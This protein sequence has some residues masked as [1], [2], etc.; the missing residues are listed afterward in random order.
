M[1][2]VRDSESYLKRERKIDMIF[3]V[4]AILSSTAVSLAMRFSN[5]VE[6]SLYGK[7]VC[8]YVVCSLCAA[9]FV[10]T[11]EWSSATMS[12]G[13]LNG[14]LLV[15]GLILMQFS[16]RLNG[17]ALTSLYGR[18][19]VCIP[20][21]FSI[22]FF[23]ENPTMLQCV[24][25]LLSFFAIYLSFYQA[26]M[27]FRLGLSLFAFMLISG[28]GDTMSKIYQ[29]YGDTSFSGMYFFVSFCLAGLMSFLVM[30]YKKQRIHKKEILYG[31]L[32][33]V[34]NY[35]SSYFLL[36]SLRTVPSIVVYPTYSMMTIVV[37]SI[38]GYILF[39]E[40]INKEKILTFV[41]ILV[42]I[43]LLNV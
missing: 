1:M 37:I 29:M 42:S 36:E 7:L 41:L 31:V 4:L 24:A 38:C 2:L 40:T 6:H 17:I 30:L 22:V 11:F 39:K 27:D 5:N 19:G 21:I 9:F 10:Q 25:I 16:M 8:N 15:L 3:L 23:H 18:L 33:G 13:L 14:V 12:F 35:F 20:L 28:L 34:P 26:N 43:G 32:I